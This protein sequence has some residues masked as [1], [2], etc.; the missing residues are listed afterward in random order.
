MS[1]VIPRCC[2]PHVVFDAYLWP[3]LNLSISPI[4]KAATRYNI[5]LFIDLYFVFMFL[6][7]TWSPFLAAFSVNLQH[8]D[9]Q[10]VASLCLDGI[11]CAIRIGCIFGMQVMSSLQST[12]SGQMSLGL[13]CNIRNYVWFLGAESVENIRGISPSLPTLCNDESGGT[14]WIHVFVGVREGVGHVWFEKSPRNANF[15]SRVLSMILGAVVAVYIS[16]MI[17]RNTKCPFFSFLQLNLRL[18]TG[19]KVGVTV[20][21]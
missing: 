15:I 5:A 8:S 11:R 16:C 9:D 13:W 1:F 12:F 19:W 14:F 3:N 20:K 7:V 17:R 6:Q 10:Q 2:L 18:H 4:V 21:N